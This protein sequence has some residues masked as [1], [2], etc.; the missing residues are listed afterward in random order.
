MRQQYGTILWPD[1]YG[2]RGVAVES[3]NL[4]HVGRKLS[5]A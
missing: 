2:V 5:V 1:K 3:P 4:I